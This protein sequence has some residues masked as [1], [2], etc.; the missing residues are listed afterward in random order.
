DTKFGR[1]N[2]EEKGNYL[3]KFEAE[4]RLVVFYN[5]GN[6]E[7]IDQELTQR[8]EPEKIML[9]EKFDA[10]KI[11]TAVYLDNDKMQYNVKRFKIETTTLHSKFYFIKE[12]K[13][14]ALTAVSSTENAVLNVTTGKG[15]QI[16]NVK[17]KIDNLVEVM[18]WKAA[19][20]KL[21]DFNKNIEMEW[22]VAKDDNPQ[23]DLFG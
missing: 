1:L 14:N 3:G 13:N 23:Q 4:D 11:I 2:S 8:F 22:I 5:D 17:F 12:G 9:L 18:G 16:N 7:I 19:G 15:Q 6:Y 21:I 20:A 10:E